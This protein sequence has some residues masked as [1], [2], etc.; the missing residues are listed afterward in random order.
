MDAGGEC[1]GVLRV[2]RDPDAVV[3]DA[4]GARADPVV[5][6][7]DVDVL[8]LAAVH[9]PAVVVDHEERERVGRGIE[10][11][12]GVE[13]AA[14]EEIPFSPGAL[15]RDPGLVGVRGPVGVGMPDAARAHDDLEV[16][17]L[18]GLDSGKV[19]AERNDLVAAL[20]G[21]DV[22]RQNLV[23]EELADARLRLPVFADEGE[24]RV[25]RR[26]EVVM[27]LPLLVA[28]LV[29]AIGRQVAVAACLGLRRVV[30]GA[31]GAAGDARVVPRVVVVLPAHPAIAVEGRDELDLVAGRA[32]LGSPVEGFQEG[33]PVQRRLHP[34]QEPVDRQERLVLREG[35][36]VLLGLLD[37]VGAV[38]AKV[39]DLGDRV[40]RHAGQALLRLPGI[41]GKLRLGRRAHL[42]REQDDRIMAAGA[43]LGALAA[44][45]VRHHLDALAVER[46]VERGKAVCRALPLVERV[47]MAGLAVVVGRQ[48][49]RV[50]EPLVEG[51]RVGGEEDRV[52]VDVDDALGRFLEAGDDGH[53]PEEHGDRA[54]PGE[55]AAELQLVRVG[56]P[57]KDEGDQGER[58][59]QDVSEPHPLVVERRALE[60]H[61]DPGGDADDGEAEDPEP[62]DLRPLVPH[63][64]HPFRMGHREH[65]EGDRDEYAERQVQ[66]EHHVEKR[67][68]PREG[69]EVDRVGCD[70]SE[71]DEQQAVEAPLPGA[72][73]AGGLRR[74]SGGGRHR[75]GML[76]G[77]RLGVAGYGVPAGL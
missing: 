39:L 33:L 69:E 52:A 75:R 42:S 70:Q 28:E 63:P 30:E 55:E 20:D 3:N 10:P 77:N 53:R 54:A 4:R 5:V 8:R 72:Q 58:D 51:L 62:G 21:E 18:A 61:E 73:D 32:E 59:R 11:A 36:R 9:V 45:P 12:G 71:R 41:V 6:Q 15:E 35:E 50:E 49:L 19:V 66:E 22:D 1:D 67:R 26:K 47:G 56:A 68:V 40:A 74:G 27:E 29:G 34:D 65:E 57:V 23:L 14:R 46:I 17:R 2:F 38:A 25:R 48:L 31:H 76:Q 64:Y 37:D 24:R 7:R 43:P 44:D 13:R 16:E 60:D